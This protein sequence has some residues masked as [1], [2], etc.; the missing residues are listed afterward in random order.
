M[1]MPLTE[2][3]R[4]VEVAEALRE[5]LEALQNCAKHASGASTQV[6]MTLEDSWLTFTVSD[7]GPGFDVGVAR[8]GTG[9]HGM[10]DRLAAIGGTLVVRSQPGRGTVVSGRVPAGSSARKVSTAEAAV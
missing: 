2:R 1:T 4:H 8:D 3:E 5:L 9:L 6:H 7:R 10:A